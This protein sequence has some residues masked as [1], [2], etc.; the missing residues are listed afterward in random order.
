MTDHKQ[1]Y[2]QDV[3]ETGLAE[4]LEIKDTEDA[5]TVKGGWSWGVSGKTVVD[6]DTTTGG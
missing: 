6:I 2:A 5:D 3:D 1:D 4:D